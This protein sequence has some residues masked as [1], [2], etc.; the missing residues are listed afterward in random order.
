MIGGVKPA[1][2][3][4]ISIANDSI[5]FLMYAFLLVILIFFQKGA[6]NHCKSNVRLFRG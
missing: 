2:N 4:L 5:F 6:R 3:L 1:W